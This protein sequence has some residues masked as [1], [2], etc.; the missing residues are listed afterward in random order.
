MLKVAISSF[1]FVWL[2]V[3]FSQMVFHSKKHDGYVENDLWMTTSLELSLLLPLAKNEDEGNIHFWAQRS[4]WLFR[5]LLCQIGVRGKDSSW[6][7]LFAFNA[8]ELIK[9]TKFYPSFL[10]SCFLKKGLDKPNIWWLMVTVFHL[11]IRVT[12]Q[13]IHTAWHRDMERTG[14]PSKMRHKEPGPYRVGRWSGTQK[15]PPKL[16]SGRGCNT[17]WFWKEIWSPFCPR[18]TSHLYSGRSTTNFF[19]NFWRSEKTAQFF[20]ITVRG[21]MN[22]GF[23]SVGGPP[24]LQSLGEKFRNKDDMHSWIIELLWRSL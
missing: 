12:K 6:V 18:L 21:H 11:E 16:T 23:H 2:N 3:S 24:F 5:E 10:G 22:Q 4:P 20:F 14:L 13:D 17:F 15:E 9:R 19:W 8:I 1:M 7:S